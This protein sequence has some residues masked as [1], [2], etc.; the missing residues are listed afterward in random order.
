MEYLAMLH[1]PTTFNAQNHYAANIS[2]SSAHVLAQLQEVSSTGHCEQV[3]I[4]LTPDE[5]RHFAKLLMAAA[6]EA[7]I[8]IG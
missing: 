6:D 1:H 3:R 7:D 5:A 8:K 4:A 2:G